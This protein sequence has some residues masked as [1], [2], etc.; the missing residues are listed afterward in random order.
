MTTLIATAVI[1]AVDRASAVFAR[2]GAAANALGGRFTKGAAGMAALSRST[3]GIGIG[4][5]GAVAGMGALVSR[6]Q[7]F[8]KTLVGIQ[9]ARIS[10]NLANGV[11][12]FEKLRSEAEATK[13]EALRLSE[14]L[15]LNP[16]GFL[17]SGEAALKMGLASD[18]VSKLME[19]SGSVHI[20]DRE[21][22]QSAATEFLGTMGTL[23]GADQE[24]KNYN[25]EITKIAN[26]WLGVANMTRTT[27]GRLEEG[28]R[29]FAP[30]YASFGESFASTASLVGAMVQGGQLDTESGTALKS[31]GTRMLN[32]TADAREAMLLGGIDRAKYMDLSAVSASKAFNNL[33]KLSDVKLG[34]KQRDALKAKLVKAQ[35]DGVLG[36]AGF[37]QEFTAFYNKITGARDQGSKDMNAERIAM[38]ILTGG[39]TIKM[40]DLFVDLAE[41]LE[42]GQL[43]EAQMAKIGEGKHLSRYKALF[44]MLPFLK[45]LRRELEGVTDE[46]TTGGNKLWT[47][48]G[49]ANWEGAIAAFDRGLARL[50]ESSGVAGTVQAFER[51]ANAIATAPQGLVEF[52]GKAGAA[53]TGLA[54]FGFLARGALRSV[55]TL[56]GLLGGGVLG[57]VLLG[58]GLAAVLF[59]DQL[60]GGGRGEVAA[61]G[62]ILARQLSPVDVLAKSLGSLGGE[63]GGALGDIAT[64]AEPAVRAL[65]ELLGINPNTAVL[66]TG[67][68]MLAKTIEVAA[69]NVRDLRNAIAGDAP[70]R[71]MARLISGREANGRQD[72]GLLDGPANWLK[73]QVYGPA[74]R[75][76]FNYVP[77]GGPKPL[78]LLNATPVGAAGYKEGMRLI[79]DQWPNAGMQRVD[80]QGRAQVGVT[81][82]VEGTMKLDATIHIDGN[83]RVVSQQTAGGAVA[84]DLNPGES[85]MD[86]EGAA[87]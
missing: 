55:E 59:G 30:L 87:R 21:M 1:T 35:K 25:A 23:F 13:K 12:N 10:D 15:K 31:L 27:A 61:N 8:E 22:S 75:D 17:Q 42:S 60:F 19:M 67:L 9:V 71:D 80:V 6:T 46:F 36:D 47:E 66:G 56:A 24:G 85:S 4:A 48:S 62:A 14:A 79:R 18:K 84:G 74:F 37:M 78:S 73:G 11:I 29:Q 49:A 51:F 52:G 65:N 83:G 81:G 50:R 43:S 34:K 72:W 20:Q 86:L 3:N 70:V 63:I 16:V 64:A 2:V 57:K 54:V 77:E 38:A 68:L 45:K 40:Y 41:K 76:E 26:Q 44:A 69:E 53:A 7:E 32:P 82:R 33:V 58:G 5:L 39:G 28:L